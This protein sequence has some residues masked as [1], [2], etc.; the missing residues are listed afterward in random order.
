[1]A[2]YAALSRHIKEERWRHLSGVK[3][4]S[5]LRACSRVSAYLRRAEHLA[6]SLYRAVLPGSACGRRRMNGISSAAGVGVT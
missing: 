2:W 1:M 3:R 5:A 4:R 6:V